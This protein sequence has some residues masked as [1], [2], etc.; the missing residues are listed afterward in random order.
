VTA[1]D[2]ASWRAA[3][4][5]VARVVRPA[6]KTTLRLAAELERRTAEPAP[7][8]AERTNQVAPPSAETR[9]TRRGL[10]MAP[11]GP[12]SRPRGL[13]DRLR[14]TLL[15][16]PRYRGITVFRM[17][18]SEYLFV[19]GN[20]I[21]PMDLG[22]FAAAARDRADVAM[23]D[24]NAEDLT[25]E[26]T[27][28]RIEAQRP[29]VIVVKGIIDI[30]EHELEVAA[31]YKAAHPHVR[32][33]LACRGAVHA[34]AQIFEELPYLDAIACGEIDAFAEEI[35]DGVEL[36][37]I[38]GMSVPGQVAGFIRVVEDLDRHPL[39]DLDVMPPLWGKQ[40]TL[41][42]YGVRSGYFVTSSRGCPYSCTFCMVG[43]VDER[44]FRFRRRDPRNVLEEIRLLGR[45]FGC[46]DFFVFDEIFTNAHGHRVSEAIVE[47]GLDL[48]WLCEGKPDLVTRPML[49]SMRD[50]GCKT[51]YYGV[52]SG[53]D[54]VLA[55]VQ[56]GHTVAD[57]RRA[58]ELTREAGLQSAA[59]VM[60]GFPQDSLRTYLRLVRFLLEA[61]PDFVR[62]GFLAP[63]P[64][65]VLH[66]QMRDAGLI[67]F[68]RTKIDRR[69]SP[70]HDAGV[71]LRT[72]HLG[73][74]ALR[75]LDL[76]FKATFGDQ[77][78]AAPA[79][80]R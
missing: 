11:S 47:A 44:P 24:A 4:R 27:H 62:Y 45:R 2:E 6:L 60:F 18:R 40:Y 78:M 38:A 37:E 72:H 29:D 33:V 59:Y 66:R 31:R 35:A 50:A 5:R 65:T 30:L 63:Y 23:I 41:P 43:G 21:P 73:P 9:R 32:I 19:Q 76:L 1:Q 22:Y 20:H 53:D 80:S 36:G 67:D 58:F 51:I 34:E 25:A 8:A 71:G 16:P 75:A 28:R 68:D 12:E 49:R 3:A 15:N 61:R 54:A 13:R 56:K 42:Y 55:Q 74:S 46:R 64:I 57:A 39:P 26:E 48:H 52:E 17:F 77:L 10:P 79:P 69:I 7:T 14:I 70:I